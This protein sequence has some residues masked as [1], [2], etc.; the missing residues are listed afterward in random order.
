MDRKK[1]KKS[2][3]Y[4]R[5]FVSCT[6]IM[7]FDVSWLRV[8]SNL[9]VYFITVRKKFLTIFF[10]FLKIHRDPGTMRVLSLYVG[11]TRR[12]LSYYKSIVVIVR[13]ASILLAVYR[14]TL[15]NVFHGNIL[16][17]SVQEHHGSAFRTGTPPLPHWRSLPSFAHYTMI[18]D[19]LSMASFH[20]CP[21][22]LS[23]CV[24]D[25]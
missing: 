5:S 10:F 1:I 8:N 12:F 11:C 15:Y 24:V 16:L 22:L 14:Q 4:D 9:W 3:S 25:Y 7:M 23:E 19:E 13:Y 18:E 2:K 6:G 21:G 17:I 20:F